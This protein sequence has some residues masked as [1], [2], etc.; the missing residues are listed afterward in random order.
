M[1]TLS[2]QQSSGTIRRFV[3]LAGHA[4]IIFLKSTV[5]AK[6]KKRWVI[7]VDCFRFLPL[8]EKDP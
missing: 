1:N 7:F 2:F 8:A 6:R 3:R 4:L 5:L